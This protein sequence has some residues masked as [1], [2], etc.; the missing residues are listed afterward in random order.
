[1]RGL[2][3]T[4]VEI[5]SKNGFVFRNFIFYC[6][7]DNNKIKTANSII[8]GKNMRTATIAN[9]KWRTSVVILI[10]F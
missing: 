8:E 7:F 2:P 10:M 6:L 3:N 5:G 4:T 1:L 9:T